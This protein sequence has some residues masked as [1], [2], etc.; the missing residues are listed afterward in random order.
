MRSLIV[1]RLFNTLT[2]RVEPLQPL[3]PGRVAMYHCGPTV[4]SS[5][6]IGNFRSFLL[7][8]LLRRFLEDQ[9]FA[10]HQV[11]NITDVGHMTAD[12]E[13]RGEDKLQAAARRERLDP[14]AIARKYEDE[15]HECLEQ[16][17]F[18]RPHE[19]PRATE[20]IPEMGAIIGDLL[21]KGYAYQV[22]G[23]VY[24]EIARFPGYGK[25]SKKVLDELEEGARVAVNEQKRD[26]R[27]FALWKTDPHHL[28]QW[29]APFPGGARGF[30][31]WHIE[32][33]AMAMKYLGH[34]FDIHTG[35]EDNLFPHHECEIA[36]SEAHTGQPFVRTWLH[37][38][39]LLVEGRKMAKSAGNFVTVR[40]V[41]ARG[42][43]GREL[44]YALLR[45]QYRQTLNFTWSGLDEARA[46]I[47][48]VNRARA[49]LARIATG[50]E[51]AGPDRL[52]AE[53]ARAQQSFVAALAD[54]LN[55]S[56]ALAVVF[57]LVGEVNKCQPGV[58]AA[59]DALAAFA[60]FDRVLA[61]F[62]AVEVEAPADQD[63]A[64]VQLL[65]EREAARKQKD[66]AA[67]D[68]ARDALR[69][70]GFQVI[71]TPQ[72]PRLEPIG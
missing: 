56:E 17:Q 1:L 7:A 3:Q 23:N 48:R 65:A 35:G 63:P 61:V 22:D 5:P 51:P 9:G 16:L 36:Q 62:G 69:A 53:L 64:L 71:D 31:G 44:R 66:W 57:G 2:Q 46:A 50:V 52:D 19:M 30:P 24:F 6:H 13:D 12:D 47:E 45:V 38:K 42:Y 41:L 8:D 11:M 34:S 70:R 18:E 32:C 37:V 43:T 72:G 21:A 14:W 39:H 49:R 58:A 4:Y 15:F 40:D 60:R 26:P 68:R 29:D 27:D 54:D 10:V 28:M 25:L 33:S 67:A 55:T 59:T 20:H